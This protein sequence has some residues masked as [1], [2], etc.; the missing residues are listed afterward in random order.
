MGCVTHLQEG[1]GT[2]VRHWIEVV[3]EALAGAA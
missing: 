2:P 3:D 1:T